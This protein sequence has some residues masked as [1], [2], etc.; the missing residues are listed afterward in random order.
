LVKASSKPNWEKEFAQDSAG[1]NN[2][3]KTREM[4]RERERRGRRGRG[5][6]WWAT[7]KRTRTR[8]PKSTPVVDSRR[9]FGPCEIRKENQICPC[10]L[11]F[12][13]NLQFL[14]ILEIEV[15]VTLLTPITTKIYPFPRF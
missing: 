1:N 6:R 8:R 4:G 13:I 5:E 14:E 7:A 15:D 3:Q 2:E 12:V 11:C 9:N 10:P